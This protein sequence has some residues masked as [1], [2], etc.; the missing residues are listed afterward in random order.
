LLLTYEIPSSLSSEARTSPPVL[1]VE[2]WATG[3]RAHIE[4]FPYAES[5][6]YLI[7]SF[8]ALPY[9]KTQ[10]KGEPRVTCYV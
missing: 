10:P 4:Q 1:V 7:A 8:R 3:T 2:D 9:K 6:V 5:G